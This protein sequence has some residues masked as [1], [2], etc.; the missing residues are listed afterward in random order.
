MFNIIF[1]KTIQILTFL[2][3]VKNI[4]TLAKISTFLRIFSIFSL[5]F[6]KSTIHEIINKQSARFSRVFLARYNRVAAFRFLR[7]DVYIYIYISIQSAIFGKQSGGNTNP[8]SGRM[9]SRGTRA[10]RIA[11]L[12]FSRSVH[13]SLRGFIPALLASWSRLTLR[14]LERSGERCF[15]HETRALPNCLSARTTTANTSL[16]SANLGRYPLE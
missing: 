10:L 2:S 14:P 8:P 5:P 1:N 9:K 6:S 3:T 11:N 12:L 4:R 16:V 15:F 7:N 13:K